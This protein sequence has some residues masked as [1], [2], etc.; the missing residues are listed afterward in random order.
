[1]V[2]WL[3]ITSVCMAD[4]RVSATLAADGH[5]SIRIIPDLAWSVAELRVLGGE[6]ADL[7]PAE[8]D[9]VVNVEGWTDA[10]QSMQITLTAAGVDGKGHTWMFDVEPFRTPA[11]S[12]DLTPKR[13]PWPFGKKSR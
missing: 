3:F 9:E 4:P 8:V 2:L 6:T 1:M 12:P 11:K 7:G 10:H 5:Y 13:R